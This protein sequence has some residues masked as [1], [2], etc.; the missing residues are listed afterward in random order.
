VVNDIATS[1][2][3]PKVLKKINI[4]ELIILEHYFTNKTSRNMINVL[5]CYLRNTY[6][7]MRIHSSQN[8]RIVA[9][10]GPSSTAA[11]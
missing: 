5:L 8:L 4:V 9:L 7:Y 2:K 6:T 1:K 3:R 11:L 10:I